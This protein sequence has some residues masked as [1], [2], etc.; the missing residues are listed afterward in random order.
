MEQRETHEIHSPNQGG[1]SFEGIWKVELFNAQTGELE[2]EH[3]QK[4]IIVDNA[5]VHMAHGYGPADFSMLHLGNAATPSPPATTDTALNADI[6]PAGFATTHVSQTSPGVFAFQKKASLG[7][8]DANT[9]L[10]EAG[11]ATADNVLLNRILFSPQITKTNTQTAFIT[12]T[13]TIRRV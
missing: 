2:L 10:T 3:E 1:L 12:T 5:I 7:L 13:I 8:N 6:L 4:N 9:T 11:L